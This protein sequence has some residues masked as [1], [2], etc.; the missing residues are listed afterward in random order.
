[1]PLTW[2]SFAASQRSSLLFYRTRMRRG[3]RQDA[4][5][6]GTTHSLDAH[7]YPILALLS[8]I[9]SATLRS[10]I[11]G[12]LFLSCI[13]VQGHPGSSDE[14]HTS[15]KLVCSCLKRLGTFDSISASDREHASA[16]PGIGI[17]L[18]LPPASY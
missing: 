1:M 5:G 14:L 9:P 8:S 4:V 6:R 3:M 16:N 7:S 13:C 17:S 2:R 12:F 18:F 11:F 10:C 15:V